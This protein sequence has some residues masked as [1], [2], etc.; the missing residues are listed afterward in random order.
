MRWSILT[1]VL[2]LSGCGGDAQTG[3]RNEDGGPSA[4][5]SGGAGGAPANSPR[6]AAA[7]GKI[8]DAACAK[9]IE[10][11]AQVQG[12]TFTAALCAQVRSGSITDCETKQ[13]AGIAASSDADVDQCA[14]ELSQTAC[15]AI[16]NQIPLDPPTCR[17]ISPS[18]NTSVIP[19]A[20]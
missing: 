2:V 19:C 8:L 9:F 4:G 7:C 1:L 14:L 3:G 18:P 20:P 17:K 13:G 10:C 16:C 12:M 11:H 6:V 5:G 15:T